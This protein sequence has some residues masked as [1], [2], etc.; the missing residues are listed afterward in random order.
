M[1]WNASKALV[2]EELLFWT[3]FQ[4]L[5]VITI[6]EIGW[7]FTATWSTPEWHCI[8]LACKQASI[9]LL[10][11]FVPR[12]TIAAADRIATAPLMEGRLLHVRVFLERTFDFLIV[13]QYA[14]NAFNGTS[15]LLQKRLKFWHAMQDCLNIALTTSPRHTT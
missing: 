15:P 7:R 5:D 13:Y 6:Q 8:H 12:T 4:T 1:T 11:W 14:W 2:Y 3:S 10:C 9:F